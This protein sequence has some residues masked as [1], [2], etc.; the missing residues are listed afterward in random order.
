MPWYLQQ[1]MRRGGYMAPEGSDG[2]AGGSGGDDKGGNKDSEG[3]DGKGGEGSKSGK[4]TDAEAALLKEVMDKKNKLKETSDQLEQVKAKLKDWEGLDAA[5]VKK[6]L[7]EQKDLAARKLEEKGEWDALKKQMNDQ[8][9]TELAGKDALIAETNGKLTGLQQQIADLTVGNAFGNSKFIAEQMALPITKARILF[10][11]HFEYVDGQ[12]VGFDKPAGAKSRTQ[13]VDAKGEPLSFEAAIQ[14][15]VE[16]DSD[17]DQLMK[18]KLR[19][20]AGS[21]TEKEG[22][23]PKTSDLVGRDRISAG[24]KTLKMID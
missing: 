14:K 17:R 4:P 1:L 18:S 2:T 23:P 11:S 16:S 9:A 20:G 15:L 24:L 21:R 3:D 5:D 7:K 19:N 10:G 12:V 8:H 13:L 6:L 22:K